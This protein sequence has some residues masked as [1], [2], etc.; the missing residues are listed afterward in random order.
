VM[1]VVVVVDMIIKMLRV[2]MVVVKLL[3]F[4]EG[5]GCGGDEVSNNNNNN[6]KSHT[7]K[8]EMIVIIELRTEIVE[9]YHK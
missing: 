6:N 1:V 7:G 9:Q 3:W 2:K 4:S 5:W 8:V